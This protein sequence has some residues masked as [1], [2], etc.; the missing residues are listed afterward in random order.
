M[1]YDLL[2]STQGLAGMDFQMSPQMYVYNDVN[3]NIVI[4]KYF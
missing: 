2:E 1:G 4:N 3:S